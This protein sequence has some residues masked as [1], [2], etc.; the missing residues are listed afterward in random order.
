MR[1]FE[2]VIKEVLGRLSTSPTKF[3]GPG[4][5]I[6]LDPGVYQLKIDLTF[7]YEDSK[8]GNGAR[9]NNISLESDWP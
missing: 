6:D 2:S 3:P 8:I 1:D 7:K 4:S 5:G 9:I